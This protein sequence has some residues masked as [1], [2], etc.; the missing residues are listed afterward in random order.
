VVHILFLGFDTEAAKIK[1][2]SPETGVSS[3]NLVFV[4]RRRAVRDTWVQSA[5]RSL[6]MRTWVGRPRCPWH[7]WSSRGR[8]S[9]TGFFDMC[10]GREF[11]GHS[12]CHPERLLYQR[13]AIGKSWGRGLSVIRRYRST[14][15]DGRGLQDRDAGRHVLVDVSPLLCLAR[16]MISGILTCF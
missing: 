4:R 13:L 6:R 2:R 10:S 9:R 11:G 14:D 12:T 3:L 16:K 7:E 5:G 8:T 15:E 1:H